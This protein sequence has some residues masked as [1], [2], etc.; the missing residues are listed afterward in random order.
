MIVVDLDGTLLNINQ[1]C[2]KK[3]I[4]YLSKLKM[5]GYIIVIATG[6]MLRDAVSVLVVLNLPT[7]L[8]LVQ[9]L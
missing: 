8:L 1:G 9:V 4:K 7:I 5:M 2:S 3:T 6:R